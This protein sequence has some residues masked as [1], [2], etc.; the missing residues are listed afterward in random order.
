L[1]GLFSVGVQ[2]IAQERLS[3]CL[4]ISRQCLHHSEGVGCA[5]PIPGTSCFAVYSAG[6]TIWYTDMS[7]H[8]QGSAESRCKVCARLFKSVSSYKASCQRGE[9]AGESWSQVRNLWQNLEAWACCPRRTLAP[10][11]LDPNCS[12]KPEP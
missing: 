6:P 9:D 10:L 8:A 11:P 12:T 7:K 1:T 5:G 4:C 2:F 3:A